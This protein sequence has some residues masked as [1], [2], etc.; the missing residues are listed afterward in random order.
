MDFNVSF[1]NAFVK[2][3]Y[4]C[5]SVIFSNICKFNCIVSCCTGLA[6]IIGIKY[7]SPQ[8]DNGKTT[9]KVKS[10]VSDEYKDLVEQ[11]ALY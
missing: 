2:N 8:K 7:E 4:G 9:M 11:A 1:V 5:C 3:Y 6:T 10:F